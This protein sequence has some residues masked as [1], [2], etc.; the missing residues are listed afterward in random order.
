ME[1]PIYNLSSLEA[2]AGKQ[3]SIQ[4]KPTNE[5]LISKNKTK[6]NKQ[7]IT[8]KENPANKMCISSL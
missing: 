7:T 4:S 3:S 1:A 8:I 6:Q 5:T 2:E